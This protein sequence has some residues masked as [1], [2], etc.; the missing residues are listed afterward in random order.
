MPAASAATV[1]PPH[2]ARVPTSAAGD[3][4]FRILCQAAA[5]SVVL[6]AGSLLVVL[7]VLLRHP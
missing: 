3:V 6:L 1:L 7:V 5:L 4:V 2:A